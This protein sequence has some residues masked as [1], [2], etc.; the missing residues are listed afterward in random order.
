[1]GDISSDD[2]SGNGDPPPKM[3]KYKSWIWR[4]G[5]LSYRKDLNDSKEKACWNCNHCRHRNKHVSWVCASSTWIVKHLRDEH[6][7]HKSKF[8][9]PVYATLLVESME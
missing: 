1:M 2:D 5:K 6:Q 7:I 3:V 9:A 8:A 4:Y